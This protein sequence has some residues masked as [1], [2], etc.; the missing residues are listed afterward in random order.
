[1]SKVDARNA[2][3]RCET[4]H[5]YAVP[6]IEVWLKNLA[7]NRVLANSENEIQGFS[8]VFKGLKANGLPGN[9]C[10]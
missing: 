10:I 6:V 1:M 7:E 3:K 9:P 2:Q 4:L 5:D 8:M